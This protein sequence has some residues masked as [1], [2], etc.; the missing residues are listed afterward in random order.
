M[1]NCL[2]VICFA[3]SFV[4]FFLSCESSSDSTNQ[5]LATS[6]KVEFDKILPGCTFFGILPC[7]SCPGI[8]TRV[9]LMKDGKVE[10]EQLYQ[11]NDEFPDLITGNY[12]IKGDILALSFT[13]KEDNQHY[14]I[15]SDTVITLLS[16]DD[17][18]FKGE[19]EALYNLNLVRNLRAELV[20]GNYIKKDSV[21]KIVSNLELSYNPEKKQYA[22][23][24]ISGDK[25]CVLRMYSSKIQDNRLFFP[26][27]DL[28]KE[29]KGILTLTFSNQRAGLYLG[30][31]TE[32]DEVQ[33][34]CDNRGL[35]ILGD[36]SKS[37]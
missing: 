24:Y 33:G 31:G 17:V 9:S 21:A 2:K 32:K 11:E 19:L 12:E 20:V 7:A 18:E 10:L 15:K 13:N 35:E 1:S 36:Y 25:A 27:E 22:L 26:L 34:L 28:Q 3:L 4:L 29:A 16:E 8:E 30:S 5:K 14:K 23:K 37:K 6:P